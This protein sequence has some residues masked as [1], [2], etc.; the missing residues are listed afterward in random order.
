MHTGACG[1][2]WGRLSALKTSDQEL[3]S[4]RGEA[5]PGTVICADPRT[6]VSTLPARAPRFPAGDVPVLDTRAAGVHE[7]VPGPGCQHCDA[8]GGAPRR[9]RRNVVPS[10]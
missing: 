8:R 1:L 2:G 9:R 5:A 7:A 6:P 3:L 4:S 10:V